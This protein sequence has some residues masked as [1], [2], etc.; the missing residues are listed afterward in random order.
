MRGDSGIKCY[1]L[2]KVLSNTVEYKNE[3]ESEGVSAELLVDQQV[4]RKLLQEMLE[5]IPLLLTSGSDCR[6]QVR[7]H[8]EKDARQYPPA[9]SSLAFQLITQTLLLSC[10]REGGVSRWRRWWAA[11][12]YILIYSNVLY[13]L[14]DSD[15][16]KPSFW[17]KEVID[18]R[19]EEVIYT[20]SVYIH[21]I[22]ATEWIFVDVS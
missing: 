4:G 9:F 19:S 10:W 18:T 1:V 16:L 2:N 6:S 11:C 15:Q 17:A 8:R 7:D 5:E 14:I 3:D 20:H 22:H 13:L 21:V 12:I